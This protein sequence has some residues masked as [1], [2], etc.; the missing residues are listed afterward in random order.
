MKLWAFR[1]FLLVAL[2]FVMA[3]V[4]LERITFELRGTCTML[5]CDISENWTTFMLM[6]QGGPAFVRRAKR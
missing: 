4:V 1:A 5:R 3:W 2:P 6:W